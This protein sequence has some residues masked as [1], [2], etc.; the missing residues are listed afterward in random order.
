MLSTLYQPDDS[1]H[2]LHPVPAKGPG[3]ATCFQACCKN[4]T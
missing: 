1:V 3:E 2:D 4:S